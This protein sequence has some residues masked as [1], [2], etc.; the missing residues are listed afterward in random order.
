MKAR[1]SA[2]YRR[3]SSRPAGPTWAPAPVLVEVRPAEPYGEDDPSMTFRDESA[4]A[5]EMAK[6][7]FA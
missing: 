2:S 3:W 5:L 6:A 7:V 1:T 4:R